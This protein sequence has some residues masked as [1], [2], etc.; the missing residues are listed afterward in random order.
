MPPITPP[1][2]TLN[3]LSEWLAAPPIDRELALAPALERIR[4]LDQTLHAWVQVSPQAPA[5]DGP[6]FG[7]PI[8]VKDVFETEGLA[9]E[10]GSDLYKGRVGASDAAIVG[11]LKRL[12]AIV[13]GKTHTA[14]FAYR[15]PAPTRNPR[16]VAHTPG[17]S[18][19]GSA[20]AVAAGMVPLALGTQTKG[21][22]LRPA[23][24]CG[25]TG[26]KPTFGVIPTDG[27]LPFSTSLDTVGF[28]AHTPRD[29]VAFWEAYA[30]APVRGGEGALVLGCARAQA[31]PT[32][33]AAFEAAMATLTAAG[34]VVRTLDIEGLLA[35]VSDAAETVMFFE[36]AQAHGDRYDEYG[37]R[38]ADVADAVRTGR[39]I[40]P[41]EYEDARLRLESYR[42]KMA[43]VFA[44]TPIVASPAATGPAPRGLASTG[45]PAMNA[46]WTALGTP[47]IAV[48]LPVPGLPLGLQ[49]TAA[50]GDDA[51]LLHAAVHIHDAVHGMLRT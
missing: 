45:D 34:L 35:A 8:G 38:L 2:G 33:A 23:S 1:P 49:L 50:R 25:I 12:G 39:A 4:A 21:S 16:D 22:V 43:A 19:S 14:A 11:E 27:V 15:S 31:E 28:F 24:Y 46:P 17:G 9:T 51:R 26:F 3:T 40:R 37:D 18:S 13:V 41:Q 5:A 29:M 36:A 48:P 7:V 6:L 32:M 30:G 10:Y 20:A 42:E 44:T 47:A